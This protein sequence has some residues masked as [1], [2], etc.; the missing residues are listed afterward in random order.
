MVE[1]L[2]A[3]H[4]G[5][6]KVVRKLAE[7]VIFGVCQ[8]IVCAVFFVVTFLSLS[9]PQ[10]SASIESGGVGN[11]ER[12]LRRDDQFAAWVDGE[13]DSDSGESGRQVTVIFADV[14]G[15]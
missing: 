13:G 14:V 3:L 11:A 4:E 7:A 1:D 2:G 10:E 15:C 9:R 8:L 5:G 6:S 12:G